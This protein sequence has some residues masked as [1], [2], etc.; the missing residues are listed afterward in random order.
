MTNTTAKKQIENTA[1]EIL[2]GFTMPINIAAYKDL[3]GL[4]PENGDG[5]SQEELEINARR[6]FISSRKWHDFGVIA[7]IP[8]LKSVRT[9]D[10]KDS[11]FI[12]IR[13]TDGAFAQ[14]TFVNSQKNEGG[15]YAHQRLF[16]QL[17]ETFLAA[18]AE[19]KK[20][21]VK[22]TTRG[23]WNAT[24]SKMDV[25]WFDGVQAELK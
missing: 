22:T 14:M 16:I 23:N 9:G 7:T 2:G 19:G 17:Q 21:V 24:S 12:E 1:F 3:N 13:N 5:S 20:L 11:R 8:Q 4:A 18:E 15:T 10:P 6:A 25:M